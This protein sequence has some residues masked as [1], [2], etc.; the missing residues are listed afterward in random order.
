MSAHPSQALELLLER[1][2]DERDEAL[3]D[4]HEAEQRAHALK[5]QHEQLA[6]YRG[7]YRQRWN[8]SFTRSTTIDILGCY[9]RFGERLDQAIAQQN[10]VSQQAEQRVQRAR[11]HLKD[12]EMR[13]ASVRKLLERRAEE[14]RLRDERQDQKATDEQAAHILRA[15]R[16]AR[17]GMGF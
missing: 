15:A 6:Q 4:L 7:E 12:R 9:Q 10:L 17:L 11:E 1:A 2:Q 5:A 8:Q 14:Q 3:R 16:A 13:L